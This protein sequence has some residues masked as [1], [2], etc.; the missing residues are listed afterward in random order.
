MIGPAVRFELPACQHWPNNKGDGMGQQRYS[1]KVVVI[2][3]A[4]SGLGAAMAERFAGEGAKLALLDIDGAGAE[5]VAARF[6]ANQVEAIALCVD[7]AD[8]ASVQA[9]AALVEAAYGCCHVLCANVGVQQ[10]GAIDTLGDQD[11]QW[12]MSVNFHGVIHTVNAF[13]P[14]LRAADGSRHVVLTAS[15]SFFQNGLRMAAYVASKYAVVG[16]GEVLRRE[17]AAD[18]I[19]VALLFPAGMA[20]RHLESSIAARPAE[21]G[22][23][24]LDMGDIQA[25]MADSGIT[26]TDHVATADHAVR[27]LLEELDAGHAY[28][29]THGNYRHQV[30]AQQARVLAAFDAMAAHP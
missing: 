11:W 23:S 22:A 12:V 25:M 28:I 2:T 29:I 18:G 10:F 5:V 6:R 14:L 30:E 24:R 27:N 8:K 21:L 16:Y 13:L 17:L 26:P 9:A 7:V 4:A 20:T 3:G 19:N 1:D 15:A